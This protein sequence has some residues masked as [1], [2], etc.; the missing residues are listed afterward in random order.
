MALLGAAVATALAVLTS[1]RSSQRRGIWLVGAA[2]TAL[3]VASTIVAWAIPMW[4]VTIAIG[5][6]VLAKSDRARRGAVLALAGAQ[7]AGLGAAIAATK[8]GGG[9]TGTL[10]ITRWRRR[11]VLRRQ[12]GQ[13]L[14]LI[15]I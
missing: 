4:T 9:P 15:H 6:A 8:V 2:P 14:S 12:R 7:L 11:G 5:Y 10:T 1:T 13:A 3:G